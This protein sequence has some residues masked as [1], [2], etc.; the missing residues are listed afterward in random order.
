[1]SSST[2]PLARNDVDVARTRERLLEQQARFL[3]RLQDAAPHD[4]GLTATHGTGETEH[5]VLGVERG[6]SAALDASVRKALDEVADALARLDAG[7]YG[8]CTACGQPIAAERLE[9]VPETR[10]CVAC[11]GEQERDLSRR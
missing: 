6:I 10:W 9:V 1:M 2:Q 11:Q 4:G 8:I 5:V 7:E 3:E